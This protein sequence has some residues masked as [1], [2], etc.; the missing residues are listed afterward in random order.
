MIKIMLV[1][2][3]KLI[4][5]GIRSNLSGIDRYQIVAE[6][7]DG[8]AALAL[9]QYT[10]VDLIIM[11]V[12]MLGMDG[13]SCTKEIIERH[14]EKKVLALSMLNENQFI[15]QM[16]SAGASGY[17]LK[18]CTEGELQTAIDTIMEGGTYYSPQVTKIIMNS[19]RGKH[20]TH[21]ASKTSLAIPITDREKE[22]LRLILKEYSNK[23]IA[24][25]LYISPRTVDAHK[26]NLLEKTG[27]KNIAGLVL[28]AINHQLFEEL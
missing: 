25:E 7:E 13:I 4:R 15:K 27:A 19:L 28:Y 1:D 23:E 10:A 20:S 26:R 2:D 12:N 14:P 5:D 18:N 22:V 8:K 6:A 17:L 11:D 24:E 16:L 9:L 21:Q 3:H